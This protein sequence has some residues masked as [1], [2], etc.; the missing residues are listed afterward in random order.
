MYAPA[1]V[2]PDF[3]ISLKSPSWS[4]TV[5]LNVVASPKVLFVSVAVP[6]AVNSPAVPLAPNICQLLGLLLGT[7]FKLESVLER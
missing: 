7:L 1:F 5:E 4:D 3:G 6:A 2:L